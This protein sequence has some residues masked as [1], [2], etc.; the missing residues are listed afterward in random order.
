MS[1]NDINYKYLVISYSISII[2]YYFVF[3]TRQNITVDLPIQIANPLI[4][5]Y[6]ILI[7]KVIWYFSLFTFFLG[8]F[9]MIRGYNEETINIAWYFTFAYIIMTEWLIIAT[10]TLNTLLSF[11]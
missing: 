9:I 3:F 10:Q 5:P 1:E 7:Y 11:F 6:I 8:S 2:C 4:N